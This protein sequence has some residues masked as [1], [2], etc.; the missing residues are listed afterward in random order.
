MQ[1]ALTVVLA[2]LAASV[3]QPGMAAGRKDI[4]DSRL[5]LAILEMK[6]VDAPSEG[7]LSLF[8]PRKLLSRW[9]S[10]S[11]PRR[12]KRLSGIKIEG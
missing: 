9:G 2:L 7:I 1:I 5:D 6:P 3:L 10:R 12:T 4:D 8:E 11:D